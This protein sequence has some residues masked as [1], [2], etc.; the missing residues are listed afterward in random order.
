MVMFSAQKY[1]ISEVI[2]FY[3]REISDISFI[4]QP[5]KVCFAPVHDIFLANL[6]VNVYLRHFLIVEAIHF[7]SN[8][9]YF[10]I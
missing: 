9:L 3:L 6:S 2:V 1:L 5:L 7:P 10:L 8:D 4:S